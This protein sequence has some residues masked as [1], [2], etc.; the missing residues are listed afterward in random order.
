MRE[1]ERVREGESRTQQEACK[2]VHCEVSSGKLGFHGVYLWTTQ[3]LTE[4]GKEE[5]K[6]GREIR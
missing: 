4:T 1:R 6:I 5:K 2:L 3:E